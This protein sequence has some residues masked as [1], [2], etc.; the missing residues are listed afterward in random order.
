MN[1]MLIVLLRV[2]KKGSV[3]VSSGEKQF[4]YQEP[5]KY[6]AFMITI[7]ESFMESPDK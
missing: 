6:K 4:L 1:G 5:L 2:S 3:V 7:T